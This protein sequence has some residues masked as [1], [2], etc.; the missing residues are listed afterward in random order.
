MMF[1]HWQTASIVRTDR[2]DQMPKAVFSLVLLIL[3]LTVSAF[4]QPAATSKE[5]TAREAVIANESRFGP[6][7]PRVAIA[8]RA[9]AAIIEVAGRPAEAEPARR[10]ALAI[11]ESRFGPAAAPTGRDL[12][13]LAG[14]LMAQTRAVEAEAA[15]RRGLTILDATNKGEGL[16]VALAAVAL[17]GSLFQQG[18]YKDA[19]ALIGRAIALHEKSPNPD[20][21]AFATALQ[22]MGVIY[23]HTSRQAQAEAFFR[24]AQSIQA[25]NAHSS[26][27]AS[28]DV[29]ANM[30]VNLL[31]QKRFAE[32]D[33]ILKQAAAD[34]ERIFGA[35][36]PSYANVLAVTATS[37]QLQR[38]IPEAISA[39]QRTIEIREKALPPDH[40]Q[41]AESYSALAAANFV[42]K[43]YAEALAAIRRSTDITRARFARYG[44]DVAERT[45]HKAALGMHL[46]AALAA[47]R[48]D[49]SIRVD[50]TFV[51]GQM[52]KASVTAQALAGA[53]AVF[54]GRND[55]LSAVVR[56]SLQNRDR[57]R[58]LEGALTRAAALPL[59]QRDRAAEAAAR[60]E[61]ERRIQFHTQTDARLARD[62]PRYAE[63]IDPQPL[64]PKEAAAQLRTDEALLSFLFNGERT[65]LW[66][67]TREGFTHFALPIRSSEAA[68][69][70]KTLR[71]G[72]SGT[73]HYPVGLAHELYRRLL[74][75]AE[76]ALSGKQHL[77]LVLDGALE[78][79]PFGMLVT[80]KTEQPTD[81]RNYGGVPW[82]AKKYVTT[83]LPSVS[84]LRLMRQ[85][86]VKSPRAPRA[87]IGFGDAATGSAAVKTAISDPAPRTQ[88]TVSMTNA[89]SVTGGIN[90]EALRAARALPETA[91]E[92]R[93]I[94]RSLNSGEDS[95]FLRE[96]FTK[97][98][99]FSAPLDQ[100][101]VVAF[102]T[103]GA[104]AGELRGVNEPFLLLT[105]PAQLR[106]ND[107]GM[108]RSSDVM[109]LKL[110]ADWVLLTACNTAASDG[111]P[112]AE[113]LSGLAKSFLSAGTRSVLVSH[114]A[115]ESTSAMRLVTGVFEISAADPTLARVGALRRSML[116]LI[117][118]P[119]YSHPRFWAP[120]VLVG[121][122]VVSG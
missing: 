30:A 18:R 88:D 39:S 22:N 11:S 87:F 5:Q 99:V 67:I 47:A 95:L 112:G 52:A 40:S 118:T 17:G 48:T 24:R 116:K 29:S 34:A 85:I 65:H 86:I 66:V 71:A 61:L 114:W 25:G 10:R 70:V 107:D 31:A 51:V 102:S 54:A 96:R 46:D 105:P 19:E 8:L 101:R 3:S 75:P 111:T 78:S 89:F 94:A 4:A 97:P 106:P 100:Y 122:G 44:A 6:D 7:D 90:L 42:D 103:H 69:A 14:N 84:S 115:V 43:R 76:R 121:E 21:A 58:E 26:Q 28:V 119:Q 109:R 110:N 32:A 15:A 77:I 68:A 35:D 108:L 2:K 64:T 27:A 60:T 53:A 80:S 33:E 57:M 13:N 9:L 63:L 16:D 49:N 98:A 41:L 55:D 23:T 20:P 36:H 50:E 79:L 73:Q 59:S 104:V 120:F 56:E 62:F 37:L 91:D 45:K 113:G 12:V 92:L 38:R 93:S 72:A 81:P 82:L 117:A 1:D 74:E 83:V